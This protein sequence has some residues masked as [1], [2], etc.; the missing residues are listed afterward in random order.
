EQMFLNTCFPQCSFPANVDPEDTWDYHESWLYLTGNGGMYAMFMP[1]E[2][3]Y[4]ST[5]DQIQEYTDPVATETP[6]PPTFTQM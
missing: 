3:I 2:N 6:S 1:I 4:D 5:L